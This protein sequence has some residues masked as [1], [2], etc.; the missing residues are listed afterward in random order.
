MSIKEFVSKPLPQ[1]T[2]PEVRFAHWKLRQ[3]AKLDSHNKTY[4]KVDAMWKKLQTA[5]S[6]A[7]PPRA[8]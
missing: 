5:S 1:G 3:I 4:M 7:L 8:Q 6:Q 2:A